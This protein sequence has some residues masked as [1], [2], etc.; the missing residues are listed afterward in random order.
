MNKHFNIAWIISQW[1]AKPTTHMPCKHAKI[2][3]FLFENK[4]PIKSIIY[5]NNNAHA[6]P[7]CWNTN[8][9]CSEIKFL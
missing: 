9:W 7:A 3:T 2:K 6:S 1:N 8:V 5:T 4:L